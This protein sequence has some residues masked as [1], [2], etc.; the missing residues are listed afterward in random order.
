VANEKSD[1]CVDRHSIANKVNYRTLICS[2]PDDT[3]TAAP[4]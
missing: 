2:T 3:R 1:S 4:C